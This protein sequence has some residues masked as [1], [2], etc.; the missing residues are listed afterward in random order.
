MDLFQRAASESAVIALMEAGNYKG[1][2]TRLPLASR[3]LLDADGNFH[4]TLTAWLLGPG[5]WAGRAQVS[6]LKPQ[7]YSSYFFINNAPLVP[8]KPNEFD[9]A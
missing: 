4:E 8:P 2:E 3:H 6:S 7:A 5:A 9:S 1:A